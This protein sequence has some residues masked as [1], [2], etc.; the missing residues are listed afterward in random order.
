[1]TSGDVPKRW[2]VLNL[3]QFRLLH[4][5]TKEV[6]NVEGGTST[7]GVPAELPRRFLEVVR[8]GRAQIGDQGTVRLG[9]DDDATPAV[10][11]AV[12]T[13]W[14]GGTLDVETGTSTAAAAGWAELVQAIAAELGD[15]E[16]ELRTGGTPAQAADV[17]RLLHD[18]Q[19][20]RQPTDS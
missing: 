16:F 19:A 1:M 20:G 12:A 8:T 15:P 14:Q 3:Q 13:R 10:R 6:P 9:F 17:A 11:G 2:V 4:Q 5:I 7:G 18:V